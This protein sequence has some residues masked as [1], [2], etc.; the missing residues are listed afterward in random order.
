MRYPRRRLCIDGTISNDDVSSIRYYGKYVHT[1]FLVN[2]F[3]YDPCIQASDLRKT[4]DALG[5]ELLFR[6]LVRLE[7]EIIEFEEFIP[8]ILGPSV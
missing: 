4:I 1:F 6:N 7:Y 3:M 2:P 8:A 5:S